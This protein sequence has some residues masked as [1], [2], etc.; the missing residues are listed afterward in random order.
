MFLANVTCKFYVE[1][2]FRKSPIVCLSY[3][4]ETRVGEAVGHE[5]D[6]KQSY[7]VSSASSSNTLLVAVAIFKRGEKQP[8]SG[9]ARQEYAYYNP[10]EAMPNLL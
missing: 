8:V 10:S 1:G 5:K 4:L 7:Q 2:P 9:G 3:F 6:T